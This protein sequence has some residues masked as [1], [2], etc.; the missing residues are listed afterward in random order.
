MR[1]DGL[2]V[3]T[4]WRP[5]AVVALC[6]F[7]PTDA[8]CE[9]SRLSLE[10]EGTELETIV[11]TATRV[12]TRL[13][14]VPAL[15]YVATGPDLRHLYQSRTLPEALGEIPGVMV[16]KT[17]NGQGSPYIR[18]YTGFRNV[19]LIDGIRLNN[20]VFR[21]G[22]N[23]YWNTVDP[24]SANRIE[25]LKG[26]A[27]VL[28]GSD[29]I[30]GAVNVLSDIPRDAAAGLMPRAIYRYSNAESSHTAR[31]EALYRSEAVRVRGGY[32]FKD[33]GD[34][35]GG[36]DVGEQPRTGYDEQDADLRLEY[37]VSSRTK[38][39]L[40]YQYVDQD[41][42]WR[43]HRTIYGVSWEGTQVGSDLAL[44]FDQRR[45][46]GYVQLTHSGLGSAADTV[47]ASLSYHEQVEDQYRLRSNRRYDETG[48]DVGTTGA[49]L[50]LEK[51]WGRT[52]F[53]YGV[54]YYHDRVDSYGV[55]YNADGSIRRVAAQGPVADDATY[56]LAGIFGQ[57]IVDVSPRV[58]ATL[59]GRYTRAA[60][61][62]NQ[63]EDAVTLA[64]YAIDDAWDNFSASGR[65]S[66]APVAD[67]PWVLYAGVAQA[68]RAPNLSDLTRLD[69]A[70][71]NE[72]ETPS[73]G[74][75]P[76]T[77]VSWEAGIK[78]AGERVSAQAAVFR[79]DGEDVIV[80]TPTGRSI[81][82]LTEVTKTNAAKSWIHG[83][84]GQVS[85]RVGPQLLLFGDG[86]WL[87]GEADAFPTAGSSPVREPI[88]VMMPATVRLGARWTVPQPRLRIEALVEHAEA[89]RKLSTRDE[90]DTQRIPPGGTPGY[91]V[92]NLRS[93][94]EV[95]P[96]LLLSLAIDNLTNAD[97]RIHGSGLNEPGRNV[98]LS[99]TLGH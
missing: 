1:F 31:A 47:R 62:A 22:A 91:T 94:W 78:F 4:A 8:P 21:E 50:Q 73:P 40:G 17:S 20:P 93:E 45:Q 32:T 19:L 85:Y 51:R 52:Q 49:W 37:D 88:D 18:G 34:V 97:Y 55:Q 82:G 23:Q 64:V 74:L 79:T 92:I 90:L 12:P 63:V 24:Y 54:D 87:D 61:D 65:L 39:A 81:G 58:K 71:S 83:I 77:F 30:G 98:L 67:G 36:P 84:E 76:E 6:A 2:G 13:F 25:V 57:A 9:E 86:A 10:D 56:D 3:L 5:A 72:F 96:F 60:V 59:A 15:A 11:V 7:A 69:S 35:R 29:A 68:F 16:Q 48:F 53:V 42:A 26:P 99:L 38:L 80:R 43:T 70:R 66:F 95:R 46:L 28:Y 33:Y 14:D 41:D 44:V 75:S 89:Q 27:S